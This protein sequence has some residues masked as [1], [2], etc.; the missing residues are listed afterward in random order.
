MEM[1][2]A[3]TAAFEPDR[4]RRAGRSSPGSPA[5]RSAA[6][7]RSRWPA[8]CATRPRAR[9][10]LGTPEVTLGLLPGNGGTQRLHAAHRP[11]PRARAA[12]HRP[13]GHARRGAALGLVGRAVRRRGRRSPSTSQ[14]LAAGPPLALAAIKRC[15]HEGGELPLEQGLALERELIEQLFRSKDATEGLTAFV[16]KRDAGV[17][18]RMSAHRAGGR[19]SAAA[20]LDGAAEPIGDD[21][22]TITDPATGAH[23][24][25]VTSAGA[26]TVDRAVRSAQAAFGAWSRRGHHRPRRGPARRRRGPARARR[27]A[28]AR[29]W[30]PSR[31]RRCARPSSSCARR[32][33][34]SSTT[35][36]WPSR[37]A[38][39]PS[40]AS[41]PASRVASCAA[42]WASS[43]RSCRGTSPPPC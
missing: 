19:W 26:E 43:R 18:G 16:E 33:T 20:F 21:A 8:T 3:A 36:G 24:G 15:V 4:R 9:Y 30:W 40:T 1:I 14:R 27:R 25:R 32:P 5:T 23:V 2:R 10:R 12:A 28:G 17:R 41:I 42:R 11:R 6:G 31:A 7:W 39:S 13:H 34:R 22:L 29:C 38:G 35:P 37:C